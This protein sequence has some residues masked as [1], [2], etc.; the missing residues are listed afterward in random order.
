MQ[1]VASHGP[2]QSFKP[3]AARRDL[4]QNTI[5]QGKELARRA[6]IGLRSGY[7]RAAGGRQI[8]LQPDDD[9]L[10]NRRLQLF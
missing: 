1:F 9:K 7:I 4:C 6:A 3:L 10:E 2:R 5:W 8:H